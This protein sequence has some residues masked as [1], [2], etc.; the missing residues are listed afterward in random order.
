MMICATARQYFLGLDGPMQYNFETFENCIGSEIL[1]PSSVNFEPFRLE[2]FISKSDNFFIFH[3]CLNHKSWNQLQNGSKKHIQEAIEIW[4]KHNRNSGPFSL[5]N[6]IKVC[7]DGFH[8]VKHNK[9]IGATKMFRPCLDCFDDTIGPRPRNICFCSLITSM[10]YY[11]T[12]A[13]AFWAPTCGA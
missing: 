8:E 4:N 5:Y 11:N 13:F 12:W 6:T 9:G 2:N 3:S 1:Y 7:I 10:Y